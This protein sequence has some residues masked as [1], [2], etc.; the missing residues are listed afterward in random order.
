[1]VLLSVATAAAPTW[2]VL[3]DERG[4]GGAVDV[5]HPVPVVVLHLLRME[6]RIGHARPLCGLVGKDVHRFGIAEAPRV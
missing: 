1:M 6:G 4:F 5:L 3:T 2:V